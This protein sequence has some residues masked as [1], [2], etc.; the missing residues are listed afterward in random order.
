MTLSLCI[1]ELA[2]AAPRVRAC[3]NNHKHANNHKNGTQA[4]SQ[5][6]NGS[7][8]STTTMAALAQN[9]LPAFDAEGKLGKNWGGRGI[10][11]TTSISARVNAEPPVP[12]TP[13][14]L[15]QF[16]VDHELAPYSCSPFSITCKPQPVSFHLFGRAARRRMWRTQK[17]AP[18]FVEASLAKADRG[19]RCCAIV[20]GPQCFRL[21]WLK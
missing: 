10:E 13:Y 19:A 5:H 6:D 3:T 9:R 12:R 17:A 1:T 18:V 20:C 16:V 8:K 15:L 4:R 11:E 21:V 7:E 14:L 2:A